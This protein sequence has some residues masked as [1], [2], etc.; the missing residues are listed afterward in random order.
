MIR[1]LCFLLCFLGFSQA[2][3]ASKLWNRITAPFKV[4]PA[5]AESAWYT[6]QMNL[7][8]SYC[9]NKPVDWNTYPKI[10]KADQNYYKVLNEWHGM[11]NRKWRKGGRLRYYLLFAAQPI[12]MAEFSIRL[13]P[14]A[15]KE[16]I[17]MMVTGDEE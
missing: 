14:A 13:M 17:H 12:M 15:T 9:D 6:T 1:V 2:A 4:V 11:D 16:T 3:E 7:A 10:T 8:H 5:V